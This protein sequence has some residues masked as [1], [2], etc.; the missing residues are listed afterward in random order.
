MFGKLNGHLLVAVAALWLVYGT[1]SGSAQSPTTLPA[2][3]DISQ[4]P[5]GIVPMPENVDE[6]F[7]FFDRYTKI[8]TPNGKPIHI[9]IESGYSDAQAIYSRKV[10]TN[11]LT[12]VADSKYGHDKATIANA[13]SNNDAIL[14]LFK[15]TDTFR[16]YFRDLRDKGV[17][18]NGQDLR[19]YETIL[20]GT[21]GYMDQDNPRRDAS[22]EEIM[23]FV[24]QWGIMDGHPTL[25]YA[26]WDAF[27]D[28]RAKNTYRLDSNETDEYFICGFEAYYDMWAHD[29]TGDGTR[30]GE[31]VP[32]SNASLKVNDPK[33]YE[34]IEGFMGKTWLYL[35]EVSD[36]FEGTF[37]LA[38]DSSA[39]YTNKSQYLRKAALT[40]ENNSNLSG[41]DSDNVLLGNSGDNQITLGAGFDVVDGGPGFD[42]VVFPGPRADYI[43]RPQDGRLIV[44]GIDYARDGQN[45][46]INIEELKFADT[47]VV[48]MK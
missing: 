8:V 14:F 26:L 7:K 33:M 42:T 25:H 24:Q 39:T 47:V 43:I 30:E 38:E 5:T 45:V 20:E 15:D 6:A 19:A 27:Y 13:I 31:Y 18:T 41:N 1:N 28:A 48:A 3:I 35:A 22:Y 37:S 34:I 11:H 46:L 29:P 10:L 16:G 12:N 9:L 36:A 32:I 44:E 2:D 17:G 21:P 23:H 4:S 40:G